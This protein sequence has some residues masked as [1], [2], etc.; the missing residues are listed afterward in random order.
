MMGI[1]ALVI[2]IMNEQYQ[3][4]KSVD[5]DGNNNTGRVDHEWTASDHSEGRS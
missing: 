1:T 2:W 5:P 3:I 4:I